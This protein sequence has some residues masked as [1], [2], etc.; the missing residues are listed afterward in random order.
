[1]WL[2]NKCIHLQNLPL[3]TLPIKITQNWKTL[4]HTFKPEASIF[5]CS[6]FIC[7]KKQCSLKV[8]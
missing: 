5:L 8:K 1:M 7:S 6:I 3:K 2:H 4:Q